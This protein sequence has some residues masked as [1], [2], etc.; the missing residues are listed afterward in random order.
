MVVIGVSLTMSNSKSLIAK[1]VQEHGANAVAARLGVT[2]A[3]LVSYLAG[4]AREA[5]CLM[6]EQRAGERLTRV[7]NA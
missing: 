7:T 4:A 5:T 1:E 6:I 3:S 2:R